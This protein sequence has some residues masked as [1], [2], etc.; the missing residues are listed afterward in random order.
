LTF[1]LKRLDNDA[2]SSTKGGKRESDVMTSKGN[3]IV[4]RE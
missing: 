3:T 4:C 2:S 1:E